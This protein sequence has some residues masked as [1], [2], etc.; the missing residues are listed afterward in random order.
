M[1]TL[2]RYLVSFRASGYVQKDSQSRDEWN[3]LWCAYIAQPVRTV[4]L[5][6]QTLDIQTEA[7]GAAGFAVDNSGAFLYSRPMSTSTAEPMS[8]TDLLPDAA[9]NAPVLVPHERGVGLG[10]A[11]GRRCLGVRCSRWHCVDV[12][13]RWLA[14]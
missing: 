3:W 9:G 11:D 8:A 12:R 14:E 6:T 1:L 2:M 4:V 7:V 13:G 5:D 10:A